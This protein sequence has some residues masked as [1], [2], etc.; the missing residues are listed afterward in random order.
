VTAVEIC[1]YDVDQTRKL[2]NQIGALSII[3]TENWD[4]RPCMST[5]KGFRR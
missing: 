4:Q 2:N 5:T 3:G 1:E